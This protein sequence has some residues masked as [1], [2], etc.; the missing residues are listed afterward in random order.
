MYPTT[1]IDI[2]SIAYG[3]VNGIKEFCLTKPGHV[4]TIHLVH[5]KPM[6]VRKVQALFKEE[7]LGIQRNM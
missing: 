1:P 6:I 4:K 2:L 5:N 7:F 3:Y